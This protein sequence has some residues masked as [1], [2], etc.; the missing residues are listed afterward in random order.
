MRAIQDFLAELNALDIKVW[1][2]PNNGNPQT[3]LGQVRLRCNAPKGVLTPV[4]K[5]QLSARKAE[6]IA[7]LQ[8][9]SQ[10]KPQ[11]LSAT[12]GTQPTLLPVPHTGSIPLS[13]AQQRLWFLDRLES[14]LSKDYNLPSPFELKGPL[15]VKALKQT[16]QEIVHRH[17]ILRTNFQVIEEEVQ[18][19]I[20]AD[21][22]LQLP[23]VDLQSLNEPAQTAEVQKLLS[24]EE[25]TPFNLVSDPLMR[26]TLVRLSGQHHILLLSFHHIVFDG[27]SAGVF[28]QEFAEL[29]Q[30]FCAGKTPLLPPLPIQYADYA[31]WQR[32]WLQGAELERQL[33]Y[34]QQQ[35]A[36]LPPPLELPSTKCYQP[37]KSVQ[38][39]RETFEIAPE[40]TEKLR[41]LSR[42]VGATL[43]M[44]VLAVYTILL[45]R[46][47]DQEDL[48]IGVP[49]AGRNHKQ[50]EQLIGFFV[51]TL[52]LR[53]NL[54]GNPSF[55]TL[56]RQVRQQVLDAQEHQDL[57][58]EK[59]VEVLQPERD[60]SHSPLFRVMFVLQREVVG[61]RQIG[62]LTLKSLP[63]TQATETFDLTLFVTEA[64]QRLQ[65][66]WEYDSHR[67]DAIDIARMTGHFQ[68]LLEAILAHPDRAIGQLP[69]LTTAERQQLLSW[70]LGT[71]LPF[72]AKPTLVTTLFEACA[73]ANPEAI[74]LQ[75]GDR[76]L[77]YRAL[78]DRANQLA[79][80]LQN[81]GVGPEILVGLCV[82]R[83]PDMLLGVL[84]ILK[85]GGAYVPMDPDYPSD[86]LTYMVEDSGIAVLLT[87][88]AL[89]ARLPES[90]VKVVYLDAEWSA[91]AQQNTVAP[92]VNVQPQHLA[93]VIYTS[94][95]TGQPKGVLIEHQAIASHCYGITEHYQVTSQDRFLQF[96]SL[97]FD[98]ALEEI[99]P[100]LIS[101]ATLVLTDPDLWTVP[102]FHQKLIE[103]EL[104]FVNIPPSYWHQWLHW[105]QQ[106][107]E[108]APPLPDL[109]LVVSGSDVLQPET[110]KLWQQLCQQNPWLDSVGLLNAYGPTEATITTTTFDIAGALSTHSSMP[111]VPI[112]RPLPNRTIYIL[113]SNGNPTPIGIPGELHIGGI[114]LAR[115]YLN[116]PELTVEKF[117]PNPFGEGRLYKTGD[118]ARYRRDGNIEFIGRIDYQ[119]K[120]RGFR[121]ELGEIQ[122]VLSQ[123]PMVSQA[124]VMVRQDR[125]G[126][127]SLVAYVI[128]SEQQASS[129]EL[130]HFLQQ[131]LPDYMVPSAIVGLDSFPLTPSGKV[132]RRGLPAPDFEQGRS[133]DFVAPST[134][135][136][137]VIATILAKV[138]GQEQVGIHD[139]FFALGGHSLLATKVISRLR[140]AFEVELPV[141]A[142]FE[143]PTVA[144]LASLVTHS[145]QI[146]PGFT[147]PE[148]VPRESEGQPLPLSFAQARLWFLNQ[149]E[150]QPNATYNMPFAL[151]IK[152]LLDVGALERGL[153]EIVQRHSIL[154]TRIQVVNGIPLQTIDP[155]AELKLAVVEL[156]QEGNH[157]QNLQKLAT[158]EAEK[159]F[160]LK[161][162]WPIRAT[163]LQLSPEDHALFLTLHHIVSDGWSID[164]LLQELSTL[165]SAFVAGQ[166]SPLPA[167]PI[168]YVDYAVWQRQW[169]AGP[170]IE[171]QVEYWKQ[172]LADVCSPINLP[173]DRP[174]PS[175]QRF[176][177]GHFKF[178][179]DTALSQKLRTLARGTNSTLFMTLL[180]AFAVLLSRYSGQEDMLIG[181]P[182]ANRHHGQTESLIGFF[183]NTLVLRTRTEG[184]PSFREL[185]GQVRQVAL[186]A[187]SHQDIP[188]EKVVEIL[189]PERSLSHSPLFQVMFE[190]Q[191]RPTYEQFSNLTLTPIKQDLQ[192]AK[193]DLTLSIIDST[194][195]LI[196]YWEYNSDLFDRETI[197]RMASNFKTLLA[198]IVANPEERVEQLPLLSTNERQQLLVGWN[199]TR[200]DYP[201]DHC[202]HK[203]FETQAEQTPEAVAVVFAG[204]QLTYQEL[205]ARANQLAHYLQG[206]GV[207]PETLVGIC[208]ERSIEMVVGLLG[209]LKAGGAY[210]TLDPDYPTARLTYMLEDSGISVL[211]TH[212]GLRARLPE[213]EVKVVYLDADWSAIAQQ[214]TVAPS[215]NVQPQHLAYVIY[216][217]GSTGQPK[218]VLIEHQAIASHCYGITEHYQVTS[219]DRFLQFTSLSFDAALE[220]I[221]PPLISGATL[222]LTDPDLWTVPEF[223]Q[224]LMELELTF[225]NLPPSYWHQW[226]HWQQQNPEDAPPLPDLRL[227]VSGS[228]VLQPETIKLWQ[229]LC[230]QN[231]WLDSVGLLNAYGPTEATITTTTFDIAGALNT[232]SSMPRVPIG[233]PLPNRTIYILDSNGN[234]TPIGI[235]GEL[236]IGGIGL[237]RGYLNRP[238]LTVEKFI[239][240]PFGEGRLYKT[241][242]LARYRRDGNIEFLGRIDHQVKIRGFRIELGEIESVLSGHQQVQE[243]VV[244][245]REDTPGNKRLVAY[246][247]GD[248]DLDIKALKEYARQQ[249]PD[250]MVPSVVV[251]LTSLP[252][253]LSGKI[254]RKALPAPD[255]AFSHSSE[256]VAPKTESQIRIASLFAEILSLH[257]ETISLDDSFFELGGHSLLATQLMFRIREAFEINLSLRALFDYPSVSDFA[258]A[259]DQALV[260]G[261][262]Q[263]QTWDLEAEAALDPDIQPSTAIAPIV[264]P[265]ERIFLTGAT[266]FLGIHLLSELLTTTDATV[267]C[268]VRADNRDAG[269]E[270]LK[271]KLEATGLWRENFTSRIIPIIGDL[272][273]SRFGLSATEYNN[274]CQDIDVVYHVGAKVHHLWSY[275]LLKDANVL[276][277]QDVLRLASLG[278]IKPL[279]YVSTLFSTSQTDQPILESATTNHSDLP[280]VGYVQTKW[281]GE[282]LVWEAKERGLPITIY[283]PS[284]ISGHSQ[285]GVSSFDDLLSRLVKGCIRLQSFPNWNG[286]SENL[287]PVDYVSRAIVCLSQQNRLFGKAFHLINPKSVPFREIFDWVRSLGYSLEEID[288]T[289]WR[290]KLIEDMENPLYPYLPNFPESP[291]NT[292]NTTNLI[293]YDC[294]NVVDGL[295]GSGIQ[296]PEVNQD[297]FKTY[298]SFF[299]ESGFVED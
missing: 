26:V 134:P 61:K 87:Q 46:Y 73:Q 77:T 270:R 266:G 174:R 212:K 267:Y 194:S 252:L 135:A 35:F 117:I 272:G 162:D 121:I 94:G 18:Q 106:N 33:Q 5:E 210:V 158:A 38:G 186:S 78:N 20:H 86:R 200:V 262:Y 152:G 88:K 287:V 110:I 178:Q 17:E 177:G 221:F 222:V 66:I 175:V 257:P 206:L 181:T 74:A 150:G 71:I 294:R 161:Q 228:D 52:A 154:R 265:I 28:L 142:I 127:K 182:V 50:I 131:K 249:L 49:L 151:E 298:L 171:Q 215:V 6:I 39:G 291:S 123:H 256:F 114:G 25:Q 235:P 81:Q 156:I 129:P 276:G 234:P 264:S 269:K 203:L 84:G 195:E 246:V 108:D 85:A 275:A 230:Q 296:L 19:T 63:T 51:N 295:K 67:F 159:P 274:L 209:I 261:N 136:E 167:L 277:T 100:P 299:R 109:R 155:S 149:L 40:S 105:Q 126:D 220:E 7:Y 153:Q 226:L 144:G 169:L 232:D 11:L 137:T 250:Y 139:N 288:Y 99:F 132:N 170:V 223:H 9:H 207:K 290:S 24:K 281:V 241:G 166:P 57:P 229:Q 120:I 56:L 218:G 138:L 79:H 225:V 273:T 101:G 219:Q 13:F 47:S 237:A 248:D 92:S 253:S 173:T 244:I 172:Q 34:W 191:Q 163:L 192:I 292:T 58:F 236:H 128:R 259:I 254:D 4:L 205:N 45:Y 213:S 3:D 179:L 83:S 15:N 30:A 29:Y 217:S 268:L 239:P 187:Y 146:T 202:I 224:K 43:F 12:E 282:Q 285:T 36:P 89:Q 231:P 23:L 260:T 104:T 69:L 168:Q 284:R 198:G 251:P 97:S 183:V 240:N 147:V 44:T 196:G 184:N 289:D 62:E 176:R 297:L 211:L 96:T 65:C 188:F 72:Q 122:A 111:R 279:H 280:N 145:Q 41:Q 32:Q 247:V 102:E 160:D 70:G 238:E 115:G 91:I 55:R 283:R 278:K 68:T 27:W 107:P 208:V 98:A 76:Q 148:I 113:D 93:Y 193:F 271:N 54:E 140:E 31:I 242:D 216:T 21:M 22:Q 141:R 95:S 16:L 201:Q 64:E 90:E 60:L 37:G 185:L 164:L 157:Q 2:D 80:Y 165:Y 48:T 82:D 119:V 125:P 8:Q 197:V 59:L 263:S 199:N 189:Q 14:G 255:P 143:S 118:L 42:S 227:V 112:G 53:F 103:L 124:L 130:R 1:V 243:C 10:T 258:S 204:E 116:R 286:F 233:R 75:F 133:T 190:L 180:A 214:D 293:E 245:P